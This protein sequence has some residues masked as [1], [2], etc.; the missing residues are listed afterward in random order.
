MKYQV[1]RLV[2]S[3]GFLLG[4][5]TSL[6]ACSDMGF[7]EAW[8]LGTLRVLA[9]QADRPEVNPLVDGSFTIT[10]VVSDL[11]GEGRALEYEIQFCYDP[12]VAYGAD[13]DCDNH[14]DALLGS[15]AVTRT[16]VLGGLSDPTYTGA[17]TEGAVGDFTFTVPATLLS[18]LDS[19]ENA[20]ELNNGVPFSVVFTVTDPLTGESVTAFRR[21]NATTRSILNSNPTLLGV[22]DSDG[23]TITTVAAGGDE[24]DLEAVLPDDVAE[25]YTAKFRDGSSETLTEAIFISWFSSSGELSGGRSEVNTF[26]T[27]TPPDADTVTSGDTPAPFLFV[28]VRDDRGGSQ[29]VSIPTAP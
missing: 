21:I 13:P 9:L 28:L 1:R 27:F 23:N 18:F 4:G 20:V 19:E 8:E 14:P 7:P 24:V 12:A 10:P 2:G 5:L 16:G 15:S 11:S 6:S 17:V 25:S 26:V 22:Q 29:F 3:W